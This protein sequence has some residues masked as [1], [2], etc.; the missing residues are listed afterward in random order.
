MGEVAKG[1]SGKLS[2]WSRA[3]RDLK[4]LYIGVSKNSGTPRWMV[5]NGKPIK[6]DG[7]G[8]TTIFGNIHICCLCNWWLLME[9]IRRSQVEEQV[10]YPIQTVVVWDFFH[11]KQLSN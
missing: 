4:E 10:V 9:E 8:A 6:M 1:P 5:Y 11:Q 3:L 2:H 7:F